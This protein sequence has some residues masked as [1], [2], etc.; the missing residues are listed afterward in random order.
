MNKIIMNNRY[1]ND[2]FLAW[3]YPFLWLPCM[4]VV[5]YALQGLI[6]KP[7]EMFSVHLLLPLALFMV[8]FIFLITVAVA[9]VECFEIARRAELKKEKLVVGW[10]FKKENGFY[11]TDIEEIEGVKKSKIGKYFSNLSADKKNYKIKFKN[12]KQVL[13]SGEMVG[14]DEFINEISSASNKCGIKNN[15]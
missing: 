13:L 1:G 5:V 11:L 7:A 6:I 4:G 10:F 3:I 12:K 8:L 15:G 9:W 2:G 14:L